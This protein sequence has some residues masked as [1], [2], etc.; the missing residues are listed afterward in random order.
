MLLNSLPCSSSST[1]V[2]SFAFT[3]PIVAS[4]FFRPLAT[5]IENVTSAGAD[6]HRADA[7]DELADAGGRSAW[8]RPAMMAAGTAVLYSVGTAWFMVQTGRTFADALALCVLPFLPGD[9]AK[10]AAASLLTVPVR[11]AVYQ[12]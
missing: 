4:P 10:I 7:P 12:H 1:T 9:A 6:W 8:L 2:S 3:I 5:L 11:R